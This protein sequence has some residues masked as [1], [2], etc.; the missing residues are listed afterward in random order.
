MYRRKKVPRKKARVTHTKRKVKRATERRKPVAKRKSTWD[1]DEADKGARDEGQE[2]EF[3]TEEG[4]E[5]TTDQHNEGEAERPEGDQA[6]S[7]G[8][9]VPVQ[10]ETAPSDSGLYKLDSL[11]VT[12]KGT[13][14]KRGDQVQLTEEEL[15][16]VQRAGVRILPLE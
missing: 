4:S 10:T 11:E 3:E 16:Q 5:Q 12:I 9:E 6:E 14:Y 13:L 8:S 1:K 2:D 7:E 15:E